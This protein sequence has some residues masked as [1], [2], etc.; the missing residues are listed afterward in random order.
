MN[1]SS[2]GTAPIAFKGSVE[3][4]EKAKSG[5]GKKL[6]IG[7][8]IVAAAVGGTALAI[9]TGKLDVT[10]AKDAFVRTGDKA[11]KAIAGSKPFEAAAKLADKNPQLFSALVGSLAMAAVLRPA[12]IMAMPDDG[13]ES[14]KRN[15]TN[16]AIHAV[17]S[18]LTGFALAAAVSMPLGKGID[19]IVPDKD[20]A[21]LAK[22]LC[23]IATAIPTAIVTTKVSG[24]IR[25]VVRNKQAEKDAAKEA[26]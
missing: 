9:K 21:R 12:T 20:V 3:K 8:G 23:A 19:K 26:K 6:A 16:A 22:R 1:V 18:G 5:K 2:I 7:A 13:T 10:K 17:S 4:D 25:E 24:K 11:A 15:K 14:S